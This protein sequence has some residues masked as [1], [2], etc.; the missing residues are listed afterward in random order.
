MALEYIH[1]T[2]IYIY[3]ISTYI[4]YFFRHHSFNT[5]AGI[6]LV[7]TSTILS[8][9]MPSSLQPRYPRWRVFQHAS[10]YV[11]GKHRP[12]MYRTAIRPRCL[13]RRRHKIHRQQVLRSKDVNRGLVPDHISRWSGLYCLQDSRQE[14]LGEAPLSNGFQWLPRH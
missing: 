6:L 11:L 4:Q 7:I 5:T 10:Q 14:L 2:Y 8:Q 12:N 13:C 1:T 9:H 3:D